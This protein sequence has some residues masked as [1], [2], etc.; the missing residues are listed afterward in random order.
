MDCS[1]GVLLPAGA[2]PR[3]QSGG[4][5]AGGAHPAT[6]G[7]DDKGG[8]RSG[9]GWARG[10]VFPVDP[11][12]SEPRGEHTTAP[13]L[14]IV[15]RAKL[16]HA[17]SSAADLAWGGGDVDRRCPLTFYGQV[18]GARALGVERAWWHTR[19]S[20]DI[21]LLPRPVPFPAE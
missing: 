5:F 17:Y 1:W 6:Q 15:P 18:G 9:Q 3:H 2:E 13:F 12:G 16:M 19:Y 14:H 10:V 4:S 8:E 20:T 11:K 7:E 21:R